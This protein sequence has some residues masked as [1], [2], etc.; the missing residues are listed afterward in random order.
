MVGGM[1]ARGWLAGP[2]A[3]LAAAIVSVTAAH[4]VSAAGSRDI[5][6]VKY[7]LVKSDVD[8]APERLTDIA[9]RLL[10]SADRSAD[11]Y[12]LNV[13][14]IQ[15][16]GQRLTDPNVLAVGWLLILPWDAIGSGVIVGP[17][18]AVGT[19]GQTG[20]S[21][22]SGPAAG[23][24]RGGCVVASQRAAMGTP[25]PQ[26]RLAP[27]QAWPISRGSGVTVAVIGSGVD[28]SVPA[29]AGRVSAGADLVSGKPGGNSDC[30]GH[31]TAMAGIVAAQPRVGSDL[32][33]IAP[34]AT[35]DAHQ[36]PARQRRAHT[37]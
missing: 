12:Q 27:D 19:P 30:L 3:L 33:G 6:N 1:R 23:P 13:G 26:L 21:P 9:L 28:A 20:D 8:G 29:L 11:I 15:P 25:W 14:R 4:A 32:V 37:V 10:G 18:P 5:D 17:L 16:D 34:E 35:G 22:G 2:V 7:Y 36:G 24:D 31:G